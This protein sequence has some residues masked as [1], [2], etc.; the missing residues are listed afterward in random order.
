ML[1]WHFFGAVIFGDINFRKLPRA[2]CLMLPNSAGAGTVAPRDWPGLSPL[3]LT[4]SAVSTIG[5]R[6]AS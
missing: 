3:L 4:V 5:A 6:R 2:F 1:S